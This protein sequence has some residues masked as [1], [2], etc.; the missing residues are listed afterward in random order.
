MKK[1]FITAIAV[2]TL[3][4]ANAQLT[5]PQPSPTQTI[6]QNFGLSSVELS[7]SRPGMKGRKIFGDLVPLLVKYGVPAPTTPLP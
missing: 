5:T 1:L 2:F 7:Y 3:F 6:K 4:F